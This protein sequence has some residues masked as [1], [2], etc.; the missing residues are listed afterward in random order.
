VFAIDAVK[1]PPKLS[2]HHTP[3][4]P[5]VPCF[6]I[7][8]CIMPYHQRRGS[9]CGTVSWVKPILIGIISYKGGAHCGHC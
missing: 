9:L 7:I 5:T 3:Y 4:L 1:P 2:H 8:Y 6:P